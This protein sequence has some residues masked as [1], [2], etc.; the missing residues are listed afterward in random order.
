MKN[1][2]HT[3]VRIL[4][5]ALNQTA[6]RQKTV[7]MFT[8]QAPASKPV[9]FRALVQKAKKALILMC[10]DTAGCEYYV[11]GYSRL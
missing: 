8:Q 7:D 5:L 4:S 1:D 6:Y 3:M 2:Y 9:I 10:M 11:H